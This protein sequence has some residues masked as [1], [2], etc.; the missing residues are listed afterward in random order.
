MARERYQ[1]TADDIVRSAAQEDAMSAVRHAVALVMALP[2]HP[3]AF[4]QTSPDDHQ[5]VMPFVNCE[6]GWSRPLDEVVYALIPLLELTLREGRGKNLKQLAE[7]GVQERRA[8]MQIVAGQAV[9]EA[10]AAIVR[11]RRSAMK[12]V[13]AE[14]QSLAPGGGK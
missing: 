9:E 3:C 10:A 5:Y 14:D 2:E 12:L 4:W 13:D 8:A 6:P 11:A 1:M 7:K